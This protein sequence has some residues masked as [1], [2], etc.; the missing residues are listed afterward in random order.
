MLGFP[1]PSEVDSKTKTHQSDTRMSSEADTRFRKN[2]PE[3]PLE[4][5]NGICLEAASLLC[6]IAGLQACFFWQACCSA[7]FPTFRLL[8]KVAVLH[9]QDT[10]SW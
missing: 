3:D 8:E 9:L 2:P 4:K 6:K 10:A 5:K 1:T 7:I